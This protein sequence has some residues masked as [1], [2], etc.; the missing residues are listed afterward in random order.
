MNRRKTRVL[1]IALILL[2][3]V[4]ALAV[5]YR[6]SRDIRTDL[7]AWYFDKTLV[8]WAGVVVNL[9]VVGVALFLNVLLDKLR[10]PRFRITGGDAPP[11]QLVKDS[12]TRDTKE[13]FVK[14]R[15]KNVGRTCEDAC[16][17]RVEQVFRVFS[18]GDARP[19]PIADHDPRPLKW[20]GRDTKPVTLNR[21]AFDFV[22]LGVIRKD[23]PE[24]FRLDFADRGH[25]DLWLNEKDLAAFR[26]T[27]TVYGKRAE[28]KHFA[29]D[30]SWKSVE[31]GLIDVKER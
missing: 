9:A 31:F 25:L 21:G 8:E 19:E 12:E 23:S 5:I 27:G 10:Q 29:F 7:V 26:I 4:L 2:T 1:K 18:A 14:L 20:V 28:P 24:A 13:L 15:V 30:L 17:V 3:G 16:E 22:D 6:M 11:W